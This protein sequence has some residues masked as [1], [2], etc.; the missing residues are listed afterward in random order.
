[1]IASRPAAPPPVG[2]DVLTVPQA[3][4]RLGCSI[5]TIS[6]WIGQGALPAQRHD[7]RRW[8]RLGDLLEAQRMIHAGGVVPAWR[9]EPKRAGWRVRR[10]GK[11]PA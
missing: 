2:P 11:K 6:G 3:A 8:I 4:A 1:M 5:A 9:R 10:F 7:R